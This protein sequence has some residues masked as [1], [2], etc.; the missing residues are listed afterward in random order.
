MQETAPAIT[1]HGAG[2]NCHCPPSFP[3]LN[4]LQVRNSRRPTG[5]GSQNNLPMVAGAHL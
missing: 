1:E 3:F 5:E 4:E 2:T